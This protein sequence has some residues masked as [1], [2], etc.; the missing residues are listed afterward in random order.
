MFTIG[1]ILV[2]ALPACSRPPA[3]EPPE[4]TLSVRRGFET[5]GQRVETHVKE[6]ER[7]EELQ[8]LVVVSWQEVDA[9]ARAMTDEANAFAAM[10][11]EE[12]ADRAAIEERLDKS[13]NDL[14][15]ALTKLSMHA[16][17]GRRT[18]TPEEWQLIFKSDDSAM[19]ARLVA[20][21]TSNLGV[22]ASLGGINN[23][24]LL[25]SD[26]DDALD[27]TVGDDTERA[28][29]QQA[30]A[31][32]RAQS[33]GLAEMLEQDARALRAI[34]LDPS[35]PLEAYAPAV[36]RIREHV[37]T[38]QQSMLASGVTLRDAIGDKAFAKTR[39]RV[40][41]AA[42]ARDDRTRKEAKGR[43]KAEKKRKRQ[44]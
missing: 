5:V 29:A 1:F 26:W 44:R 27:K 7:I 15:A 39:R 33:D 21:L 17:E 40:A 35:S 32:I 36:E 41:K 31:A 16:A 9:A 3:S 43:K 6:A 18:A 4:A 14:A 28:Q 2:G 42:A 20:T 37:A 19:G 12:L 8:R 23:F 22:A 13:A 30:V 10:D 25:F 24:D 38:A 34:N 11:D